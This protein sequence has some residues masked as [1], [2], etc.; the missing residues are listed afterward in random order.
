MSSC[1]LKHDLSTVCG[2]NADCALRR[3][4]KEGEGK[5][6]GRTRRVREET[7]TRERGQKG[8]KDERGDKYTEKWLQ[9]QG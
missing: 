4:G 7:S 9:R 2:S 3:G 6:G 8:R 5:N 1:K